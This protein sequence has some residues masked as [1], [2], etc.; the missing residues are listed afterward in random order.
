MKK[1]F[2][3]LLIAWGCVFSPLNLHAGLYYWIDENGIKHFG[4]Q[5]PEG[6]ADVISVFPEVP[7]D[8]EADQKR[9]ENYREWRQ[10]EEKRYQEE[11]RKA[12]AEERQRIAEEKRR[13]K[14]RREERE[15]AR[16][17]DEEK[18]QAEEKRKERL[19]DR[20][21]TDKRIFVNPKQKP[22]GVQ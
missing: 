12:E 9:M 6:N 13:E 19:Y 20:D 5:P 2:L 1:H 21:K 16:L 15:A 22:L 17:A 11:I 3:L 18:A 4:A 10:E 14:A 8:A 7:Y